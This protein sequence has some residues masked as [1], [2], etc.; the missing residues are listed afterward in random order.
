MSADACDHFADVPKAD[1]MRVIVALATEMHALQDRLSALEAIL[2]AQGI[3]LAPLDAPVEAAALE[4]AR[5][6]RVTAFVDRV[7][8]RLLP[9][10]A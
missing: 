9:D 1:M 7:F 6:A 3:D 5:K 10:S 2:A 4:P 8:G